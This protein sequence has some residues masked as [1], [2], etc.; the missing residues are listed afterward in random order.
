MSRR[1]FMAASLTLAPTPTLRAQPVT[2]P[3]AAR[4]RR[5]SWAGV[6]IESADRTVFIDPWLTTGIWE[7]AWTSPVVPIR[8]PSR[9]A[10]VLLTHLH[11]DHFDP[12]AIRAALG[13][14]AGSVG[15]ARQMAPVVASAGFRPLGADLFEPLTFGSQVAAF[16][17]PAVDGVSVSDGQVS[18]VIQVGG[19]RII[20]CGDTMYHGHFI[21]IG[22]A[23][24][25]FDVAFLPING[26]RVLAVQPRPDRPMSMTPDDAVAA[27]MSLRARVVVPIHYGLHDPQRYLEYPRAVERCMEVATARGVTV[28]VVEP[29]DVCPWPE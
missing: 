13:S 9:P 8:T 17:V 27:A 18:W 14:A 24:G 6:E 19:K 28:R 4:V 12:A 11:N 10:A 29:G 21:R 5:L 23:Y 3:S 2:P 15:C 1:A 20:H 16:P 7:G 26:A 22:R 25:P